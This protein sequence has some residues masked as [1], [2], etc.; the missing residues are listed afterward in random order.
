M[1]RQPAAKAPTASA[2]EGGKGA[3]AD[4]VPLALVVPVGSLTA[5]GPWAVPRGTPA[6]PA[7]TIAITSAAR[8]L[9]PGIGERRLPAP[10]TAVR[11]LDGPP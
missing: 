7:E 4:A 8:G 6:H 10:R 3:V 2:D 5:A 11:P 9:E 1:V